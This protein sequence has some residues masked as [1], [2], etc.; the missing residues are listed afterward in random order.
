MFLSGRGGSVLAGFDFMMRE[1]CTSCII[2]LV[3]HVHLGKVCW[4]YVY[5]Y[6]KLFRAAAIAFIVSVSSS[7]INFCL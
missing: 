6:F 4:H 3:S 7:L 5:C 2:E 1:P